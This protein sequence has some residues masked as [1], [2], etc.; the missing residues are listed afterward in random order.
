MKVKFEPTQKQK[1]W[2]AFG[3]GTLMLGTVFFAIRS[4]IYK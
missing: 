4:E 3:L 2:I 1:N